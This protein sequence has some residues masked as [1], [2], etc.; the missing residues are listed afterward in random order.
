MCYEER[1]CPLWKIFDVSRGQKRAFCSFDYW[2]L[3]SSLFLTY[4]QKPTWFYLLTT[5][6][7]LMGK[8]MR[9]NFFR[10]EMPEPLLQRSLLKKWGET[11][12]VVVKPLPVCFA[13]EQS[14]VKVSICYKEC[15][16][17]LRNLP[18]CSM[19]SWMVLKP[20]ALSSLLYPLL[21]FIDFITDWFEIY[22]SINWLTPFKVTSHL[23]RPK[24]NCFFFYLTKRN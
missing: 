18:E 7:S 19:F 13:T 21:C 4:F 24:K 20:S 11:R 16:V 23:Q 1:A 15:S 3:S 6:D 8:S 12:V 22:L 9:Q 2:E 5:K 17:M 14:T 10:C